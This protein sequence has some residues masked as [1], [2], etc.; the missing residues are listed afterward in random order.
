ME[1]EIDNLANNVNKELS[2]K[3]NIILDASQIDTFQL[4]EERYK[5]RYQLNKIPTGKQKPLDRGT[6]V[7]VGMETYY[8]LLMNGG[9]YRDAIQ[10]SL[11]AIKVA[12]LEAGL[13][14]SEVG[15]IVEVVH[16][17]LEYW[18]A[19]DIGFKIKAVENPFI[20]LLFEDEYV[21]F[22]IAGKID[23]LVDLYTAKTSYENLPIDHK[24]YDRDFPI[25]RL[26]NQFINYS[27][28]VKS[29][30]LLVNRI[31]F[32][33]TLENHEKHKRLMLSY[34]PEIHQ[35]WKDNMTK[36]AQRYI[37][38][39]AEDSWE[40]NFTSCD[41]FH[42]L[43][44]YYEVCDSSGKEAK[45]YKLNSQFNDCEPWDVSKLLIKDKK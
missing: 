31:G 20:Y 29:N 12:S 15:R 10:P 7:H 33:K 22:F 13:E 6:L 43:C 32:Q 39:V 38:C 44:E 45:F 2:K 18:E 11:N 19:D 5:N 34:D 30:F 37:R 4:C 17:N 40:M 9:K 16:E 42:R 24:S 35:D 41:K 28:A 8:G 27:I 26:S 14:P 23:L 3:A 36:L 21:R 25:K 1:N